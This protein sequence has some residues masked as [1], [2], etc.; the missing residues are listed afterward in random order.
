MLDRLLT[1]LVL[2]RLLTLLVLGRLLTLLVL[3]RLLTLL[4]LGRLLTLF[5]VGQEGESIRRAAAT[6]MYR[7]G[8]R[9]TMPGTRRNPASW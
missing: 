4:V 2:G 3:G 5:G 1:L 7:V 6:R 9:S 8:C